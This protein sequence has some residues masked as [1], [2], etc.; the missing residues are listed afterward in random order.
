MPDEPAQ[1]LAAQVLRSAGALRLGVTGTSMLPA[2]RPRDILS[3]RR[4]GPESAAVGDVVLFARA[5]RLFA[6]R[7][8]AR[9][10][11]SLVTRGDAMPQADPPVTAT[12]LLGKV[13]GIERRGRA[14]PAGALPGRARRLA[15]ALFRRSPFAGRLFLRLQALRP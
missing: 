11:A 2:I 3:I 5:G 12:E 8:V 15:A 6:H 9:D 10:R 1:L 13:V 7:V 4:C 14:L